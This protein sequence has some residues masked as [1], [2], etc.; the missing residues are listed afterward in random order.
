MNDILEKFSNIGLA[1]IALSL[2]VCI[3]LLVFLGRRLFQKLSDHHS[4]A[5]SIIVPVVLCGIAICVMLFSMYCFLFL[6]KHSDKIYV[7]YYDEEIAAGDTMHITFK[8]KPDNAYD[9][10]FEGSTCNSKVEK[11]N[12]AGYITYTC[13][14]SKNADKGEDQFHI[15]DYNDSDIST[16]Y[17][18]FTVK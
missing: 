10:E 15:F 12:A 4:K 8:G 3:F 14:T 2:F 18:N 1:F 17:Y 7:I 11:S 6:P 9:I 5:T 16:D 13:K